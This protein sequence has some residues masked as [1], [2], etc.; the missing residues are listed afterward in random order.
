M[1]PISGILDSH[2]NSAWPFLTPALPART[3]GLTLDRS[4]KTG[5]NTFPTRSKLSDGRAR[6]LVLHFF[7]N[8]ELLA[9]ELMAV[10]LLKWPDAPEGFRRGLVQTMAEEQNHMRLYLDRMKDL[11]VEFGE[12]NLNG[13]FWKCMKDLASPMEFAAAMSMTFEQANLDFALH[14]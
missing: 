11:G 2:T 14:Y 7:A 8:H 3:P 9:L 10:A 6:G 13:F 5:E 1:A 4:K 12:A